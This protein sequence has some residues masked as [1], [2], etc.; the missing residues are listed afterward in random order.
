MLCNAL[1][2]IVFI[3]CCLSAPLTYTI[4]ANVVCNFD[5]G[6]PPAMQ[7]VM[8]KGLARDDQTLRKLGVT[9]GAKVLVV[10]SKLDD[11]LSVS[12]PT[13]EVRI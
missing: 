1:K 6:V 5:T 12:A 9:Q 7:K 11:V 3:S 8:I 4:K 13:P 2:V 10:G